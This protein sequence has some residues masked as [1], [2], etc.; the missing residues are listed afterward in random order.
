[1]LL[2]VKPYVSNLCNSM[3][4][5]LY[6]QMLSFVKTVNISK[7]AASIQNQTDSS[8]IA[9]VVEQLLETRIDTEQK[10]LHLLKLNNLIL[11]TALEY[12]LQNGD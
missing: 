8:L 9:N 10:K 4:Y 7:Y 5:A 3:S 2:L 12:L 11:Y 1:M 6:N